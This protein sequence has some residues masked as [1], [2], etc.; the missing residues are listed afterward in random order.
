VFILISRDVVRYRPLMIAAVFEKLAFGVPSLILYAGD[1][2]PISVA[3]MGSVDLVLGALFIA[4]FR[5]T[6]AGEG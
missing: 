1:R 2:I 4:A 6:R 3:V 5:A